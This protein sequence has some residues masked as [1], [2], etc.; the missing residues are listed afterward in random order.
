[1]ELC[2]RI[3]ICCGMDAFHTYHRTWNEVF[4]IYL[5]C[6]SLREKMGFLVL[7]PDSYKIDVMGVG[8]FRIIE[9]KILRWKLFGL[10]QACQSG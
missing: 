5:A 4:E 9:K 7:Y 1:M 3:R 8:L 6:V 2:C 10:A